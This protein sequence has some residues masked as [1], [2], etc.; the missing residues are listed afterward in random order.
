MIVRP[1]TSIVI[2]GIVMFFLPGSVFAAP[3]IGGLTGTAV[4]G[5]SV[6]RGRS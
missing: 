6:I 5:T 3:Q 1:A 2:T 4:H